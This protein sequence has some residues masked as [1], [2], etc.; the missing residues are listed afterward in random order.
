MSQHLMMR[1]L[2][3][4]CE[5][6]IAPS[7]AL[8]WDAIRSEPF[9]MVFADYLFPEG[10][11]LDFLR[12]VREVYDAMRL[13]IV[14]TSSSL[15]RQMTSQSMRMGANDCLLKPFRKAE[16]RE[17]VEKMLAQP[18]VR[19]NE[20]DLAV[21]LTV[22]WEVGGRHYQYVPELQRTAEGDTA[23]E[24]NARMLQL[25]QEEFLKGTKLGYV[26]ACRTLTHLVDGAAHPPGEPGRKGGA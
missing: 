24:A 7:L 15:D 10:D 6:R 14:V 5:V 4:L 8:G 3:G 20:T 9:D 21:V 17:M 11:L 1:F 23:A 18:Y 25:L 16:V 12:Q 26:V 22:E 2:D 13:P 19:V